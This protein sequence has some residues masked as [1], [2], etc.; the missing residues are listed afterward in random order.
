MTEEYDETTRKP[1]PPVGRR[2]ADVEAGQE[3]EATPKPIGR[4][5]KRGVTSE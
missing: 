5:P 1:L 3:E 2:A 4:R